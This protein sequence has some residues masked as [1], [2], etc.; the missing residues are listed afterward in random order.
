MI[1]GHRALLDALHE[2]GAAGLSPG[3]SGNISVR[4]DDGMIISASG[5]V[6]GKATDNDIVF[7]AEQTTSLVDWPDDQPRPSS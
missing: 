4:V 1:A 2:M 7:V 5:A 3:A 6:A